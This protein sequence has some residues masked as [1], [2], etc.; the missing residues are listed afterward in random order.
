MR[1]GAI[2]FSHSRLAFKQSSSIIHDFHR[3]R[4][5]QS[6]VDEIVVLESDA[7]IS[8]CYRDFRSRVDYLVVVDALNPL[9]DLEL[10]EEMLSRLKQ[11]T[12]G[13]CYSDGAIPGTQV[14]HVVKT[15]SFETWEQFDLQANEGLR[16]RWSTQQTHNNQFNLYKYKRLKMFLGLLAKYPDLHLV[17]I[18]TLCK[19]LTE[20]ELF[21]FLLSYAE[22][23]PLS[24]HESCPHCGSGLTA[25]LPEVCQPL[26]GYV[27]PAVPYYH[28]CN[29]CRLIVLSPYPEK[30]SLAQ[31]YD[32]FDTQD[33]V[34][35]ENNPYKA[36]SPRV[37]IDEICSLLPSA[38]SCLDLG[39]GVGRYSE[40]VKALHSDWMVTHS[41]LDRYDPTSLEAQGILC[42]E[43]NFLEDAIGEAQ[44]DLVTAWEVLEHIPFDALEGVL[45][46]IHS[47]L[48]TGGIF[49]F[50]TPDFDSP[51]CQGFDF[52]N[53]C[54]PFHLTVLSSYWLTNFF[55]EHPDWNIVETTTNSDFLEDAVS[56][57][58][59][60][61]RACK[62]FQL[63]GL[64]KTLKQVFSSPS[65]GAIIA[66]LREQG[67]G[68]EV[69]MSV[70]KR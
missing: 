57:F 24:K 33:F 70:Q 68:T 8:E 61:E 38:L 14:E 37:L 47:A 1:I 48:R 7:L 23:L 60:G 29:Q 12:L 54:P 43:L 44:Y 10:L 13:S 53:V 39:G 16:V 22:S 4:L 46:N 20:P 9:I 51:L 67:I 26:L 31:I 25:L 58:G 30:E 17:K 28:E 64:S 5:E 15:K 62:S 40:T 34:V 59:Y 3:R 65:A 52:Y 36:N 18:P 45:Q 2:V 42:R 50:S 6:A 27:S 69:I 49:R 66:E 19:D 32:E 35:S 11:S 41:D 63:R 56:W 21:E 55:N